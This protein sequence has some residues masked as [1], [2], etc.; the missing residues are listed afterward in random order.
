[1]STKS[2]EHK[3]VFYKDILNRYQEALSGVRRIQNITRALGT[4]SRVEQD[5]LVP[6][7]VHYVIECAINMAFNEIKYRARLVKDFQPVPNILASDGC[8]SQVFLN[9]LINAAHA[10]PEGDVGSHE[11]RVRTWQE[12]KMVCVEVRD[13]GEGI[14]KD[15]LSRIFEPFFSTKGI[16]VGS[17]LGLAISRNII[18]RYGGEIDVKSEP[19]HGSSFFIRI[20]FQLDR[21]VPSSQMTPADY[22]EDIRGRILVVDDEAG[23]CRAIKRILG[24]HN[25]Q[26]AASGEEAKALLEQDQSFDLIICDMMMPYMSGMDLHRWLQESH[27]GLAERFIFITG[28]AFT[29]KSKEYLAAVNTLCVDKPFDAG[30]FKELVAKLIVTYRERELAK[31]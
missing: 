12:E 19:G 25:V 23:I 22:T 9:L 13:T 4:F 20:P 27:P 16:G 26:T 14:P 17:G 6:V 1:M 5:Q 18:S 24:Q 30:E 3:P 29:P 31:T 21:V 2:T 10:I 11:I 7:N 15:N 28:G 8:L